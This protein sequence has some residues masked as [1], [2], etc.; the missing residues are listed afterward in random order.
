MRAKKNN[1]RWKYT[2]GIIPLVFVADAVN[3]LQLS[4]NYPRTMSV[5]KS[6]GESV[7]C[8]KYFATLG[9]ILMNYIRLEI[10][11]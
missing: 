9:K 4:V 2:D 10:R 5:G 8:S 7:I 6:V 3:I 1:S 11:W